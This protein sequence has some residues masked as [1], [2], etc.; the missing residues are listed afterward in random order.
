M[1]L[2]RKQKVLIDR[3]QKEGPDFIYAN[4]NI[5]PPANQDPEIFTPCTAIVNY[6]SPIIDN[7]SDYYLTINRFVIDTQTIP[8][9]VPLTAPYPNVNANVLIYKVAMSF[10]NGTSFTYSDPINVVY[11]PSNKNAPVPSYDGYKQDVSTNYYYVYS[12]TTFL[13]MINTAY[14]TALTNLN[15]KIA[16]G[17]STPPLFYYDPDLQVCTLK[18]PQTGYNMPLSGIPTS[19]TVQVW[20]DGYTQ[21]LFSTIPCMH[22][23]NATGCNYV[24]QLYDMGNNVQTI[25]SVNYFINPMEDTQELCYWQSLQSIQFQTGN[26]PIIPEY[27][28][29]S[30]TDVSNTN[31]Q[32]ILE[33]FAQDLSN[34]FAFNT[35][36]EYNKVDSLR[37]IEMISNTPISTISV[38][39]FWID[40]NQRRYPIYLFWNQACS[41]KF[42]FIK[43]SVYS[44]R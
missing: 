41:I 11:I 18:C 23:V 12:Y 28:Q 19:N 24:F 26:I 35:T 7:P 30:S 5:T 2:N 14:A 8:L 43:K 32:S 25:S 33:D 13:T 37:L 1:N 34:P 22:N 39:V 4:I 21:P 29:G 40:N 38:S 20:C 36:L 15:G 42:E 31:F 27:F 44:G 10:Y 3:P 9:I 17:V 16:T 6:T